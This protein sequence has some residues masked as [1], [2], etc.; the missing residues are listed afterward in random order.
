MRTLL[1]LC[2]GV[3]VSH[4]ALLPIDFL[5]QLSGLVVLVFF[6]LRFFEASQQLWRKQF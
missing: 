1:V 5:S 4:Q 3:T 6:W 2:E